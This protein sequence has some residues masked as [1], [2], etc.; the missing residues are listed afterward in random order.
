MRTLY[1]F[2][3]PLVV[4]VFSIFVDEGIQSFWDDGAANV[5]V[6]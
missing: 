2:K 1:L 3:G 5:G 4:C 6:K